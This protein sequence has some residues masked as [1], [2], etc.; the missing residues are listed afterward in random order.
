[1]LELVRAFASDQADTWS[2]VWSTKPGVVDLGTDPRE[3]WEGADVVVSLFAAQADKRAGLTFDEPRLAAFQEGTVGWAVYV[4]NAMYQGEVRPFRF[5]A[6]FHLERHAWKAVHVHR[7]VGVR[8]EDAWGVD[9]PTGLGAVTASVALDPPDLSPAAA[10]NGTVTIVFT[11]VEGSTE[12]AQRLGDRRWM[13]VLRSHNGAVR[14]HIARNR[15]YEVKNQGDGFMLAFSSAREALRCAIGVQ[16][17]F[18]REDVEVPLRVRVGVHTGEAVRERDDFFG[19]AVN[20]AARVAAA[21]R[22]AEILVS[23]IVRQL[24]QDSG[25][26]TFDGPVETTLKGVSGTQQLYSVRW[27]A[28]D[29]PIQLPELR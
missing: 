5:T 12:L 16:T 8:N 26:F 17:T 6:I 7:S 28:P 9:P 23:P 13:E 14:S 24:S 10:P 15:G 20:L 2:D 29:L 1:M 27:R 25:E 3:W 22:G 4:A 19:H 18:D 21:A 11:D